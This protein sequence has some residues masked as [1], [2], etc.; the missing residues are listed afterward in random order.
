M[1]EI[2]EMHENNLYREEES[3]NHFGKGW[4]NENKHVRIVRAFFIISIK[5]LTNNNFN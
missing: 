5:T 3:K 4:K 2:L 1:L